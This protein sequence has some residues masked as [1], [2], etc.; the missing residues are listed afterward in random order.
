V[1]VLHLV[2]TGQR[3]GAEVFAADL[4]AALAATDVD[5]RVA[6]LRGAPP[7]AVDYRV[8]AAPLGGDRAWGPTLPLRLGTLRAL[9]RLV[10][11]W[12]PDLVQAHGGEPLKYAVLAATQRR[13]P[14]IVY[15]RIGSVSG[16]LS[17]R[18]RTALYGWL[19]H[20]AARVVA[21]GEAVRME[22]IATF[23]VPPEQVVTIPNGVNPSR[24]EGGR[25]R[26]AARLAMGIPDGATVVLSLG[27]L[28]WEKD[29]CIHL[30]V[31]APLLRRRPDTVHLFAG[32]G[33]LRADLQWAIDQEGLGSQALVLGNRADVGDLLAA[34]DLLISASRTEGM[35]AS[36]IEAGMAGLP[37][38]AMGVD[39]VPEVIEHG[40]SGL[41]VAP[42]DMEGLRRGVAR[43][44]DDPALRVSLGDA[45]RRRCRDRYG[46]EAIAVA[47]RT[48]Y[49]QLVGA[50]CAVS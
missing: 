31:T 34:S 23:R 5:Q 17:S 8:T 27:A 21:V 25:G 24:V 6:V 36:I 9:R 35:P 30:A 38:A 11:A 47:Y 3:R 10:R 43:L 37:V 49:E 19:V 13:A 32:E 48:L 46:M 16:W 15:R 44:L 7:W 42:G 4:V 39:A 45:A 1:R 40:V 50:R 12:Q 22:T 14:K 26:A 20:R 2:A 28:T 41:L 18:P 29:P 33:P